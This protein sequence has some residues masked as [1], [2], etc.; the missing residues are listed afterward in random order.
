[1]WLVVSHPREDLHYL[2]EW[3]CFLAF[4]RFG[5]FEDVDELK[6][7]TERKKRHVFICSRLDLLLSYAEISIAEIST[8]DV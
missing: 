7:I 3:N 8:A 4:Y 2:Q 5:P 1:M 6:M